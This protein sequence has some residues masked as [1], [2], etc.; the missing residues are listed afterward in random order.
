ML[1]QTFLGQV[2]ISLSFNN[3]T[4]LL[5][6]PRCSYFSCLEIS[7]YFKLDSFSIQFNNFNLKLHVPIGVLYDLYVVNN[8]IPWPLIISVNSNIEIII[9]DYYYS[10]LKESDF[11]RSSSC[12]TV[13]AMK[14]TDQTSLFDNLTRL[15]YTEF[16]NVFQVFKTITKFIPFRFYFNDSC[17]QSLVDVYNGDQVLC[18]RDFVNLV[19]EGVDLRNLLVHGIILDGDISMLEV[20][21]KLVYPDGFLHFVYRP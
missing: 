3:R 19:K 15:N 14:S 16:I 11:I 18:F 17:L 21:E 5:M 13:M 9:K 2:P 10:C 7:S 8:R 4:L 20:A 12:K 6:A 1:E